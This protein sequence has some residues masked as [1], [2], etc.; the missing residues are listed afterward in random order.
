MVKLN[1]FFAFK[2][3]FIAIMNSKYLKFLLFL[4]FIFFSNYKIFATHIVGG[5]FSLIHLQD[6]NYQL[7]LILYFDEINGNPDA[8]DNFITVHIFEKRNNQDDSLMNSYN[9][10]LSANTY[11][12]F[13]N[14][15]EECSGK[16]NEV[17]RTKQLVYTSN[18]VLSPDRYTKPKGYYVVWERCCRNHSIDNIVTPED[19][20]QTFYLEF[21]A[22]VTETGEPFINSSPDLFQPLRD[23]ACLNFPFNINFTG[24]DSDGDSLVYSLNHPLKGNSLPTSPV[25]AAAPAPYDKVDFI[26]GY[27]VNDMIHGDPS[28]TISQQGIL[29]VVPNETGLFVFSAKCEEFRDGVKIGEVQRDYQL[30]VVDGCAIAPPIIS[31]VDTSFNSP[32]IG[33]KGIFLSGRPGQCIE[34]KVADPTLVDTLF[35]EAKAIGFDDLA[36]N[37]AVEILTLDDNPIP[38]LIPIMKDEELIFKVCMKDECSGINFDTQYQFQLILGDKSCPKYLYDTTNI[39]IDIIIP[40]DSIPEIEVR[41]PINTELSLP[42][43]AVN[44]YYYT[45]VNVNEELTFQLLGLDDNEGDTLVIRYEG[46]NYSLYEL[47]I[48]SIVTQILPGESVLFSW[49][50]EDNCLLYLENGTDIFIDYIVDDIWECGISSSDTARVKIH[51]TFNNDIPS[52]EIRDSDG[53]LPFSNFYS[54]ELNIGNTL[55]LDVLGFDI[56]NDSI[57][58]TAQGVGFKLETVGMIFNPHK[59]PNRALPIDFQNNP[60]VLNWTAPNC[61]FLEDSGDKYYEID[62]IVQDLSDCGIRSTQITRLQ[63]RLFYEPEPN[64]APIMTPIRDQGIHY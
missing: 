50:P 49:I 60:L 4:S 26:A 16:L 56:N 41:N 12:E 39:F 6:S 63:I 21:P 15:S 40:K 47:D 45:E 44:N 11:V 27:D 46:V 59:L 30:L 17:I 54:T 57:E 36:D 29:S 33:K 3:F 48:D 62:F 8:L 55:N 9:I 43:D 42:F 37:L 7:S 52:L 38:S 22:V 53:E 23:F 34:F 2:H 61:D 58:I 18:I 14:P 5:E 13:T 31:L 20:G 19:V 28:L 32:P 24:I 25:P 64:R 10:A 1:H 51:L 35:V